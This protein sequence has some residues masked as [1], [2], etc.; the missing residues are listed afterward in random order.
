MNWLG[1][2]FW[3]CD[4]RSRD[5]AE[6]V[7]HPR[8]DCRLLHTGGRNVPFLPCASLGTPAAPHYN[9]QHRTPTAL[10]SL[11]LHSSSFIS[12]NLTL[13][14]PLMTSCFLAFI[15]FSPTFVGP[16][17]HVFWLCVFQTNPPTHFF[18]FGKKRKKNILKEMRFYNLMTF[19][20]LKLI[21]STGKYRRCFLCQCPK[22]ECLLSERSSI[23]TR[24]VQ[25]TRVRKT[26][27]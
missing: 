4:P 26:D 3:L 19:V 13:L 16:L 10:S 8:P 11:F 25:W 24:N 14:Q 23:P 18:F 2:S 20:S 22:G 15:F 12:L 27:T 21:H 6:V 5:V 9:P 17:S 1:V 7:T